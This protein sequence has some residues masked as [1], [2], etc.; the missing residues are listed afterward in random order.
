MFLQTIWKI[1][2]FFYPICV[3]KTKNS[4]LQ[5][6]SLLSHLL[7]FSQCKIDGTTDKDWPVPSYLWMGQWRSARQIL[8]QWCIQSPLNCLVQTVQTSNDIQLSITEERTKTSKYLHLEAEQKWE[9]VILMI[10]LIN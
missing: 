7:T 4:S 5:A 1:F 3:R 2:F 10:Q 6:F 8:I 9:P